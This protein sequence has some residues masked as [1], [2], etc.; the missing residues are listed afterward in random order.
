MSSTKVKQFDRAIPVTVSDTV[1][2]TGPYT[3]TL[4][5]ATHNLTT[6]N[7]LNGVVTNTEAGTISFATAATVISPTS[8]SI[9]LPTRDSLLG[10]TLTA[11]F[12]SGGQT[13]AQP[14]FSW[15][16]SYVPGVLQVVSTGAATLALEGSLDNVNFVNLKSVALGSAGSDYVIVDAA[17][18][19]VRVNITSIA[20]STS[21]FVYRSV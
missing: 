4:V 18:A 9:S 11:K 7:I 2:G 16:Q 17:W 15:P 13:G 8:F 3:H 12:Y 5:T 6:G 21:V 10:E 14:S 20:A 19:Y 1:S